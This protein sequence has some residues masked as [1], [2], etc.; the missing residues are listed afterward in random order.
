MSASNT[1]S[2]GLESS[3]DKKDEVK[4]GESGK[5]IERGKGM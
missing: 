1:R 3:E 2:K 4:G 5:T